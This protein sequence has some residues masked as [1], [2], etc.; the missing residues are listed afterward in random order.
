MAFVVLLLL[1]VVVSCTPRS[2]IADFFM[3][4]SFEAGRGDFVSLI[5]N[6][7]R[8]LHAPLASDLTYNIHLDTSGDAVEDVTFQ[9]VVGANVSGVSGAGLAISVPHGDPSRAKLVKVASAHVG[10]VSAVS[11]AALN[12]RESFQLRVF[13]GRTE[14]NRDIDSGPFALNSATGRRLFRIP[15]GNVGTKNV[16]FWIFELQSGICT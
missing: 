10:R 8:A 14:D 13:K 3:F 4:S 11:E 6:V 16:S 1:A 7:D 5:L 15:F 2:D 12:Y 9:F